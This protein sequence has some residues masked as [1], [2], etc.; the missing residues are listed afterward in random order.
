MKGLAEV[1]KSGL[2]DYEIVEIRVDYNKAVVNI[3]LKSPL[4]GNYELAI[5]NFVSFEITHE[6]RWGKG[7]YVCSSEIGYNEI[8]KF[9]LLEIELN[10]GDQIIVKYKHEGT[11]Q[12][13]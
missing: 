6:E 12:N 3:Y 7:K 8:S 2:H 1:K 4:G 13:H 10:S 9:Y 5:E 11:V